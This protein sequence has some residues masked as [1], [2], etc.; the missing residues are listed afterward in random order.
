MPDLYDEMIR[1]EADDAGTRDHRSRLRNGALGAPQDAA[2]AGTTDRDRAAAPP[3]DPGSPPAAET[4]A[5][6]AT[7]SPDL[8]VAHAPIPASQLH[9]LAHLTHRPFVNLR[10]VIGARSEQ[11]A[12]RKL[13]GQP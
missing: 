2:A 9:Q 13:G 3:E 8:R 5:L 11:V 12:K 4:E 7:R 10:N 6:S 1:D